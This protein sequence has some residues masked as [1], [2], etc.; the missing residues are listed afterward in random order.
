MKKICKKEGEKRG[1]GGEQWTCDATNNRV[2][3]NNF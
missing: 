1:L 3:K 2:Y